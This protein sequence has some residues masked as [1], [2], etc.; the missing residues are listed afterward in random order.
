MAEG[1]DTDTNR[2]RK[3]LSIDARLQQ[4]RG[5]MTADLIGI[6]EAKLRE[7]WSPE[8]ISGWLLASQEVLVSLHFSPKY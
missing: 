2:L 1:E 7:D 8:Q 5:K 6:I 3:R 4:V